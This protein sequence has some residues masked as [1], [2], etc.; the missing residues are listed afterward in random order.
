MHGIRTVHRWQKG[1]VG[2]QKEVRRSRSDYLTTDEQESVRAVLRC[3]RDR[4][5]SM[6]ALARELGLPYQSTRH[7]FV[8]RRPISVET[9]LRV[10]RVAEL[11]VEAV[12]GARW[13]KTVRC[14]LCGRGG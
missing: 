10:A 2:W 13:A 3:L 1:Q 8:S 9:A 7:L 12:V 11:P 14:P 4:A 5:A 6:V